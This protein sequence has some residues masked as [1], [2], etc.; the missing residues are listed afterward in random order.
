MIIDNNLIAYDFMSDFNGPSRLYPNRSYETGVYDED[1][2]QYKFG[3]ESTTYPNLTLPCNLYDEAGNV[4][5]Q[6]FYMA[7]LS[8]NMKYIDLYQSNEL[9]ARVK[10]IKVVEKM[11][12]NEELDEESKIIAKLQEAQRKQKL[13][14]IKQA[15]E[16][17][18]AFKEKC[19]ANTYAE[20]YDS[21]KGY[22][23]LNYNRMGKKAKGIIQK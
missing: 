4:I 21:G 3:P 16:E 11:Y 6:G 17:L 7:V 22:Y 19:E 9:K 2:M 20:I 13:K 15:E 5:T 8:D 18:I 23:I 12:T 14:K 10:V 1:K